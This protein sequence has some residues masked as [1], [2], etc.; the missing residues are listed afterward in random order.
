[1]SPEEL[2]RQLNEE[3]CVLQ[4]DELVKAVDERINKCKGDIATELH[5]MNH[6]LKEITGA[7]VLDPQGKPDVIGHR[8][9]HA[10]MI[11]AAKAERDFWMDMKRDLA[12]KGLMGIFVIVMGLII[13]G[14]QVKLGIIKP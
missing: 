13:V 11:E 4:H 12:K 3:A 7:F 9:A 8:N 5:E 1:M 6:L 2:R 10:A 14:I